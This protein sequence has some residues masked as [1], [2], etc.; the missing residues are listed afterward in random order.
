VHFPVTRQ[1]VRFFRFPE[2][3]RVLRALERTD[4][5]CLEKG[6][7]RAQALAAFGPVVTGWLPLETNA[8]AM[9]P[10]S[11]TSPALPD[12]QVR[13]VLLSSLC[14]E[15]VE[16]LCGGMDASVYLMPTERLTRGKACA[17]GQLVKM[18]GIEQTGTP[19][20][21]RCVAAPCY[22]EYALEP[23]TAPA[24]ALSAPTGVPGNSFEIWWTSTRGSWSETRSARVRLPSASSTGSWGL[25]LEDLPHWR[26]AAARRVRI[27]FRKAGSSQFGEPGLWR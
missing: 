5:L 11:V 17:T 7:T 24:R 20:Q 9:L 12:S 18:F 27:V 16:A 6:I 25:P 26:A 1:R 8:L 14:F 4:L 13:Q 19:S 15:A 22:L 23:S 21:Y 10:P 3:E 2:Q